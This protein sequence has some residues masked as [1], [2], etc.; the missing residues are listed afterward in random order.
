MSSRPYRLRRSILFPSLAA[1]MWCGKQAQ[2]LPVISHL[3]LSTGNDRLDTSLALCT[4]CLLQEAC[5]GLLVFIRGCRVE[6]V[7]CCRGCS[8]GGGPR[9]FCVVEHLLF[10]IA[11]NV[12]FKKCC[13]I[14]RTFS[15]TLESLRSI[16]VDMTSLADEFALWQCRHQNMTQAS[17]CEI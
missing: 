10:V 17:P 1:C 2:T 12:C 16:L 9:A 15:L 5:R 14:G 13:T 4:A 7:R 8:W 11:C 3:A 6:A